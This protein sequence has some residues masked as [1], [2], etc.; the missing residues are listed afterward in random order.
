MKKSLLCLALATAIAGIGMPQ[1]A[2]CEETQESAQERYDAA[3]LQYNLGSAGFFR[4]LAN[5][6]DDD[7]QRAYEII[8][9]QDNSLQDGNLSSVDYSVH[10]HLGAANDATNLEHMKK[11]VDELN[12]VNE[13][14]QRENATNGTTLADLQVTS[15]LMAISQYQLNYSKAVIGHSQA[16]NVGENLSWGYTNPFTGWYDEEKALYDS[17]NHDFQTVGHYLNVVNSSYTVMG[18]S[19]VSGSDVQY[20]HAYG[21][22][23]GSISSGFSRNAVA[24]TSV[25]DY[26]TKFNTYY[27][28][29]TKELA[30]AKRALDEANENTSDQNRPSEETPTQPGNNDADTDQ[31]SGENSGT[32]SVE[33]NN[34]GVNNG[35]VIKDTAVSA[36]GIALITLMLCG[37][38]F[39]A[40]IG[41][42][43]KA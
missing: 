40:V 29:V 3:L 25:A 7:A 5:Q 17:G 39:V 1:T 13:Y 37:V 20:G 8:T 32:G 35:D 14:R 18:Y 12:M 31:P 6:G 24:A 33:T 9:A 42:K 16:F 41:R 11:A 2:Y 15:T 28:A 10:T 30:D 19:Y 21:Q 43:R 26:Q 34:A 4:H 38:A 23:F 27:Q 22:T 36:N